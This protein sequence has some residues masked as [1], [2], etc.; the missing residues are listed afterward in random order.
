MEGDSWES[1]G[2]SYKVGK[3]ATVEVPAGKFK[4]IPVTSVLILPPDK[5]TYTSWYASKVGVI[6]ITSSINDSAESVGVL[7][8]FTPGK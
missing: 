3:E 8:S 2:T 5:I 1:E 6:K 4:A 7:K